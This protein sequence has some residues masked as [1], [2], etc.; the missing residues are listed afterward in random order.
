MAIAVYAYENP[1]DPFPE[2]ADSGL[3]FEAIALG[4][5][6]IGAK[7]A[8]GTTSRLAGKPTPVRAERLRLS[9]IQVCA[10]T[11]IEDSLRGVIA[12]GKPSADCHRLLAGMPDHIVLAEGAGLTE[13]LMAERDRIIFSLALPERLRGQL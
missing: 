2:F 5:P 9:K 7:R 12:Y 6:L 13:R 10:S 4:H 11:R 1:D 8:Y 3:L